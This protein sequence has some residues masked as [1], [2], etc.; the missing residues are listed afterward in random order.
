M[1]VPDKEERK[2]AAISGGS[3]GLGATLVQRLR[4]QGWQVATF[5]RT[6]TPFI[7]EAINT[8]DSNLYWEAVDLAEPQTLPEFVPHVVHRFGHIDTLISNAG[9]L[10]QELLLTTAPQ[11]ISALI[12]TNLV[13]PIMLAQA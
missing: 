7:S 12:T 13:A 6:I 4:Q 2:V 3:R 1:K 10:Q 9:I 11:K 5:S 8:A